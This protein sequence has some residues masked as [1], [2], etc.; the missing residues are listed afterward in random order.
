[1]TPGGGVAVAPAGAPTGY[2][3]IQSRFVER[4]CRTCHVKLHGSN[5]P[6][7]AFFLR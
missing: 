4:S 5:H 3:T 6:A 2:P 7:G 1:M